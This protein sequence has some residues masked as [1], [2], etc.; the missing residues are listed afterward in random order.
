MNIVPLVGGVI[1]AGFGL[2]ICFDYFRFNRGAVKAQG[3]VVEY[4]EY[5]SK[6]TDNIKRT[7]YRPVFELEVEG[8][9]YRV[10]SKTSFRAKEIPVGQ[11]TDVLYRKGDEQN[12]RLGKGNN[13]GMGILFI[14]LSIPAFYFGLF[15]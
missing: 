6:D 7:M 9:A 1:F 12:A 8:V 13:P 11:G 5:L 14:G 4:E 15:R 2:Y 10:R 3:R